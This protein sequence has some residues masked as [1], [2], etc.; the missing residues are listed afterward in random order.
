MNIRKF[1]A[2]TTVA[3]ILFT[4]VMAGTG[5]AAKTPK[6]PTQTIQQQQEIKFCIKN[7]LP[8]SGLIEVIH[9]ERGDEGTVTSDNVDQGETKVLFSMD[10][11]DQC[12]QLLS[13]RYQGKLYQMEV[14]E[15]L[16]RNKTVKLSDFT[17]QENDD[18]EYGKP[19][20]CPPQS[21][22]DIN[23]WREHAEN[24]PWGTCEL[25]DGIGVEGTVD[26]A[27]GEL[28]E[29]MTFGLP[30]RNDM[31]KLFRVTNDSDSKAS[32]KAKIYRDNEVV[33]EFL[34][35]PNEAKLSNGYKKTNDP[36]RY[37]VTLEKMGQGKCSGKIADVVYYQR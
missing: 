34:V 14:N 28:D 3:S 5:F 8:N 6:Q 21:P 37:R 29:P 23:N 35:G 18:Y 32:I 26:L 36:G 22:Q 10:S 19:H 24:I 1:A 7:D 11:P 30:E 15:F 17:L 2:A 33:E 27:D 31:Q 12:N 9:E 25:E 16:N 13:Y 4:G 20:V